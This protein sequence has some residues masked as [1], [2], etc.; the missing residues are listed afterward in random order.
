MKKL[1][2]LC[3][4]LFVVIQTALGYDFSAV[5]PSGQTL[6]Y[7]MM[8]NNKVAVTIPGN[9]SSYSSLTGNLIIPSSVTYG[10]DVYTVTE[11]GTGAFPNS[12]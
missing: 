3:A 5:A 1:L 6:Y 8:G 10:N 11:I 4:S 9:N 7:D 12:L 2:L